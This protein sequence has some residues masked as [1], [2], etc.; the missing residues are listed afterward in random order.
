MPDDSM[1]YDLMIAAEEYDLD[2]QG[3]QM[4]YDAWFYMLGEERSGEEE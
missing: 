2:D 4:G 3:W 1:T